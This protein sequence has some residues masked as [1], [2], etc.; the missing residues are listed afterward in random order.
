[1]AVKKPSPIWICDRC[2][3]EKKSCRRPLFWAALSLDQTI[4]FFPW[5]DILLCRRCLKD[6]KFILNQRPNE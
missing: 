1:M 3:T 5:K 4:E 2:G 6:V